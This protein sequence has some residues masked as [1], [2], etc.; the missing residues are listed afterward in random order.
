M[1]SS[2]HLP[3]SHH[4]KNIYAILHTFFP[5]KIVG[6]SRYYQWYITLLHNFLMCYMISVENKGI[7]NGEPVILIIN[8]LTCI[9]EE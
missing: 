7:I 3:M 4:K 5:N 2:V 6:N 8:H 1:E 9:G